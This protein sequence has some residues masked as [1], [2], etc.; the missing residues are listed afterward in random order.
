MQS[1]PT[2][3]NPNNNQVSSKHNFSSAIDAT[4]KHA[5]AL[6][7]DLTSPAII[8]YAIFRYLL[9]SS[10]AAHVLHV[11]LLGHTHPPPPT[12][13]HQRHVQGEERKD[14]VT[15]ITL[16]TTPT[17]LNTTKRKV[18]PAVCT[19]PEKKTQQKVTKRTFSPLVIISSFLFTYVRLL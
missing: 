16:I 1:A 17:A 5:P 7:M 9:L 8:L 11:S 10:K 19:P 3:E 4:Q 18:H 2:N 12:P 6:F 13:T 14:C 15:T